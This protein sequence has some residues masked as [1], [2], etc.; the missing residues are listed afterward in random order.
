MNVEH[1]RERDDLSRCSM[2]LCRSGSQVIYSPGASPANPRL[3][4]SLCD[5]HNEEFLL[6]PSSRHDRGTVRHTN[7]TSS[8]EEVN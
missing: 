4:L 2:P 6:Q 5:A 8:D 3:R 7:D 1:L